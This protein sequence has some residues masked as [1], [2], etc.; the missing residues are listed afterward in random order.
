LIFISIPIET[1]GGGEGGR[2]GGREE[3]GFLLLPSSGAA[4][5]TAPF[6]GKIETSNEPD[7][8]ERKSADG[9]FP[10]IVMERCCLRANNPDVAFL[11]FPVYGHAAAAAAA[12]VAVVAVVA[13]SCQQQ[14]SKL[15]ASITGRNVADCQPAESGWEAEAVAEAVAEAEW[16]DGNPRVKS[17]TWK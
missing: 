16:P 10:W 3:R 11:A 2:E 15:C 7:D 4:V 17:A 5:S 12:V 9:R 13:G 8:N 1:G 6:K 14:E